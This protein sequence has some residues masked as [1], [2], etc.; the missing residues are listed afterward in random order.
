MAFKLSIVIPCFNERGTLEALLAAVRGADFGG[1][2]EVIVVDDASTDGSRELLEGTLRPQ[3]DVLVLQARNGGKGRAIRAGI[4]RATGDYVLVQDADLEYNPAEYARLLAP[5]VGGH[6]DAVFGS[7]FAGG[8]S[9]RVLYFWHYVANTLLTL[10]SNM[11]T[12]LNLTD[13]ETG[14]KAFRREIVQGL[15]LREDGFGI[16]PEITCKL[17]RV[18]RVRVYEVGISYFGRTYR[19]GKK[20]HWR[21]GLWALVCIVRYGLLRLT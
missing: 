5:M 6:A 3:V 10:A 9:H 17:A 2:R 1:E 11:V 19:E 15:T 4:A 8:Q 13:M 21:D 18:P 16:E 12:N 7:R 20:I 14:Y